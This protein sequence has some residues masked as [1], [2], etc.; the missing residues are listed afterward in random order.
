MIKLAK[1]VLTLSVFSFTTACS[2]IK[3]V[4]L[5]DGPALAP[6]HSSR[7]VLPLE[8]EASELDGRVISQGAQR[9]RNDSVNLFIPPGE[10]TLVVHYESIWDIDGEN[11]EKVRSQPILFEVTSQAGEVF[12]FDYETPTSLKQAKSFALSIPISLV[13]ESQ[14]ISGYGLKKEDPLTFNQ[15]EAPKKVE[16]PYLEQLEYWWKQASPYERKQF[17]EWINQPENP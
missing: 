3:D 7:I 15:K 6:E 1:F 14:R 12:Q 4:H 10:H 8:L 5:Y 9:F 13:S 2:T 16:F 11:H 17:R